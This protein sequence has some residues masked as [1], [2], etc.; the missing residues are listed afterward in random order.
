[1]SARQRAVAFAVLAGVGGTAHADKEFKM[2][3]SD[4][5]VTLGGYVKLDAILSNRSA[6]ADNPANPGITLGDQQVSPT[7]IPIGPNAG[8]HKTDQVTMH[9]RQTRLS[10]GTSTPTE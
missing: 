9:A 5:T 6:G 8:Q 1:M 3:D 10:L 2:P 7:S 4:T